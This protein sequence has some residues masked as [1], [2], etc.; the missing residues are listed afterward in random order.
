VKNLNQSWVI[1]LEIPFLMWVIGVTGYSDS[2]LL[3]LRSTNDSDGVGKVDG[4]AAEERNPFEAWSVERQNLTRLRS[5]VASE[6]EK[7]SISR[8]LHELRT[9]WHEST[10]AIIR[11]AAAVTSNSN[12]LRSQLLPVERAD[13]IAREDPLLMIRQRIQ[14]LDPFKRKQL[15]VLRLEREMMWAE[16]MAKE[17]VQ[18]EGTRLEPPKGMV[19]PNRKIGTTQ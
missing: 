17:S 9:I 16:K 7:Q 18:S 19:L 4:R 5:F 10:G 1:I 3:N 12:V 2:K 8:K 6:T 15:G 11:P 13:M 14:E